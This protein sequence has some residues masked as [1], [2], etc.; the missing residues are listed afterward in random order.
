MLSSP[1]GMRTN[2][3]VLT[4]QEEGVFCADAEAL[5]CLQIVMCVQVRVNLCEIIFSL[6][7]DD[8]LFT[9]RVPGNVLAAKSRPKPFS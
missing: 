8:N 9:H 7:T 1:T 5:G 6:L 3:G 2:I 4:Y